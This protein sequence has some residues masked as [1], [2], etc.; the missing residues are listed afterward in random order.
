MPRSG[1]EKVYV[2]YLHTYYKVHRTDRGLALQLE[3][4]YRRPKYFATCVYAV[5]FVLLG[6]TAGN[7]VSCA[8][9]FLRA[10]NPGTYG[11]ETSLDP[12]LPPPPEPSEGATK[13]L[14]VGVITVIC[15]IHFVYPKFG[16]K[17]LMTFLA[18]VKMALLFLVIVAGAVA[19]SGKGV[20]NPE[21]SNFSGPGVW[22][23]GA[24]DN[25]AGNWAVA[26]LAVSP[27]PISV[28]TGVR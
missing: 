21:R 25:G 9:Y 18:T 11:V 1:G 8:K 10:V 12:T 15:L 14:A 17:Y 4:I 26:L 19:G 23:T 16:G 22:D 6:N 2:I 20:K 13:G 3:R 5:Q 27:P 28:T 24:S 7:A